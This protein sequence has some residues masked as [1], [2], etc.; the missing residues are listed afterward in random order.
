MT[1]LALPG[2]PW[3]EYVCEASPLTSY[4]HLSSRSNFPNPLLCA[5]FIIFLGDA[6]Q[7]KPVR[8][9]F[10]KLYLNCCMQ[11]KVELSHSILPSSG[12]LQK[13]A[14][15]GR[16]TPQKASIFCN[17]NKCRL[18]KE[19]PTNIISQSSIRFS[20]SRS[21]K[22]IKNIPTKVINP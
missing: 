20:K 4:V 17:K 22:G 14:S 6:T 8:T 11:V 7:D 1:L 2:F 21:F 19:A 15:T 18:I 13:L 16:I 5:D 9:M 12:E 10:V 3:I